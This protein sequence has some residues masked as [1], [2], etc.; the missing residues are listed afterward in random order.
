METGFTIDDVRDTLTRDVTRALGRIERAARDIIDDRALAIDGEPVS[1]PQLAAIDSTATRSTARRAWSRRAR[2]PTARRAWRRSRSTAASNSAARCATSRVVAR[3]RG[4]AGRRLDRHAGDAVA[5]ARRPLARGPGD[6][7]Q[8]AVAGR[9]RAARQLDG[10]RRDGLGRR[11]TAAGR[12]RARG[13]GRGGPGRRRAR[14]GRRQWLGRASTSRRRLPPSPPGGQPRQPRRAAP[15]AP[16][17]PV[18]PLV[19]PL[20]GR[21]CAPST[22]SRRRSPT[23]RPTST[24]AID[25]DLAEVF[26]VEASSTLDMLDDALGCPARQPRRP[27]AAQDG[28]AR[29][30][31]PQGRGGHRRARRGQP[32]CGRAPGPRGAP[33]RRRSPGDRR[34]G[35]GVDP[36]RRG[37]RRLAG[38]PP[39]APAACPAAGRCAGRRTAPRRRRRRV[40]RDGRRVR[41]R[42]AKRARRGR[43]PA[44][45]GCA[46]ASPPP[47]PRSTRDLATAMHRL[48][49]SA[50]VAGFPE[51]AEVA[52]AIEVLAAATPVSADA[53][54]AE[55][56]RCNTVVTAQLG[57]PRC[58]SRP[59]RPGAGTRQRGRSQ[60]PAGV[61]RSARRARSHRARPRALG[62]PA[63]SDRRAAPQLPH[64]EGRGERARPAADSA[65]SCTSS[66]TCS[67]GSTPRAILPPLR[68][69]V[70]TLLPFNGELRRQLRTV[71]HGYIELA[72]AGWRPGSRGC[73]PAPRARPSR[74]PRPRSAAR[75]A[76]RR[77]RAGSAAAARPAIRSARRPTAA[78]CGFRSIGST[79]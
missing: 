14:G 4:G 72:P 53:L 71:H 78:T 31:Y 42:S 17:A 38:I 33:G 51:L 22:R 73:S 64:A 3:H 7:R 58:A 39:R 35:R 25:P 10:D 48:R 1:L 18:R 75:T 13:G 74:R 45:P 54:A 77:A 46:M 9:G 34:R 50:L 12:V 21:R 66:R 24:G 16:A 8:L 55:L 61:R 68:A 6:R 20:V 69:I 5:R 29:F 32:P 63:R 49:G 26:A 23:T 37:L 27:R 15:S 47:P 70:G 65:S 28:G 60:L 30:P 36:R 52:A 67:S 56:A 11:Q 76:R 62:P 43:A 57:A 40:R 59:A 19:R 79:R 2:S 41:A 44:A